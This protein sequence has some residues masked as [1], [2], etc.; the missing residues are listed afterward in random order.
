LR[1]GGGRGKAFFVDLRGDGLAMECSCEVVP[2]GLNC[3]MRYFYSE[4][5]RRCGRHGK[6]GEGNWSLLGYHVSFL[7]S[8]ERR[9]LDGQQDL[10]ST[11]VIPLET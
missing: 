11:V 9:A 6:R 2:Y 1:W 10:S 4:N 8:S 7:V 3:V 5:V